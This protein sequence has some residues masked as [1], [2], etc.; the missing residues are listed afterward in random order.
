MEQV[1]SAQPS[2]RQGYGPGAL[3]AYFL[4]IALVAGI[5]ALALVQL[6][7]ISATVDELT[8]DLAVQRGLAKDIAHQVLAT[9]FHA[10]RYVRTQSQSDVDRFRRE[11]DRLEDLLARAEAQITDPERAEMLGQIHTAADDYE[12]VF[13]EVVTL[14]RNR[15]RINAEVLDIQEHA[16]RDKLTALRVHSVF[17][18]DPS[19]FLAFGNAQ[20][21]LERMR[22]STLKFLVQ[23]DPKYAVEFDV[24]YEG[25]QAA[26]SNLEAMLDDPDQRENFVEAQRAAGLYHE[27]IDTIRQEQVRLNALLERMEGELE[28]QISA[29]ASGIVASVEQAYQSRNATS[30]G[31]IAQARTVLVFTTVTAVV[32]GLGLGGVIV[33]RAAER[34]QAHEALQESERRYRTLFEG[35]PVGLY[36]ASRDRVILDANPTLV[37]ML[38]YPS[39]EDLRGTEIGDL[40]V[41]PQADCRWRR[42]MD[43]EGL[44]RSFQARLCRHDESFIWIRDTTRAVQNADGSVRHY[45]G[46]F[47]DITEQKQVEAA[48]EEAEER[49]LRREKLA[50]L[51]QLAGGVAHELRNPLGVMSNAVYYLRM[52]QDEDGTASEEYLDILSQEVHNAEKIITDLL[53]FARIKSP[54]KGPVSVSEIVDEALVRSETSDGVTVDVQIPDQAPVLFV[55]PKQMVQVL[56]NLITN[57][58]QAMPTG[59]LITIQ[60]KVEGALVA[61]SVT[62][63]GT[64]MGQETLARLFEPL[65]TTKAKGIG[66]GLA[67]SKH[68]VEA[69]GGSIRVRSEEGRG[70]TFTVMLP[71]A[72]GRTWDG[73]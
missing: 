72:D 37:E 31:L 43:E 71:A 7:R 27:G 21:A 2:H 50:M 48:L 57:A 13:Q 35:V 42:I 45:E 25:A 16:M 26:F 28:P 51:G 59:G 40:Y 62:D 33:R 49:L 73:S 4:T 10:Q 32:A 60:A 11:F 8:G 20:S 3:L 24:A 67:V 34:R 56:R 69:N 53:D 18:N 61:V 54:S 15:Q 39:L 36:R 5:G 19:V 65:F 52:L 23:R 38:A 22:T 46:G 64:G 9:R 68:L 30:K 1:G 14:I 29:S 41:D 63:T 55:D 58:H 47:E 6:G 17:V 66:L 12:E 70:S 44:V